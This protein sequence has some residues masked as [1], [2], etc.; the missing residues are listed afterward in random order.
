M[1][2]IFHILAIV[3]AALWGTTFASSKVLLNAGLSPAEIMTL[4]FVVAYVCL[5]P[6]KRGRWLCDNWKDELQMVLL[7]ITGGALY[8]LL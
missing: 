6:F 1:S 8:F 4:R 2:Y 3:T 7:G 5:L